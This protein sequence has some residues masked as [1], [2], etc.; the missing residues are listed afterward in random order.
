[1]LS[2]AKRYS[3]KFK[4]PSRSLIGQLRPKWPLILTI[5]LNELQRRCPF[6]SRALPRSCAIA[7]T[8]PH[9]KFI[10]LVL[11][12]TFQNSAAFAYDD[13]IN[14]Q[15]NLNL[16]GDASSLTDLIGTRGS[17]LCAPV[18]ITHGF[19]YLRDTVG[20]KSLPGD[21]AKDRI[22]QLYAKCGTDKERGTRYHQTQ[23]C[24][25]E[26]LKEAGYKPWVYIVGPH[27][28]NAPDGI[29]LS[30]MRHPLTMI[31]VKN[32]VKQRLMVIMAVGWYDL[33]PGTKTYKRIGGHFFN[34]YGYNWNQE[35][36]DS[37][38]ELIAVNSLQPYANGAPYD[39][40]Q[41]TEL[42]DDGT[43]YPSETKF[44]ITGPGFSFTQKTLVEDLFVVWPLAP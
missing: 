35:W 13:A 42:P 30:S 28:I 44:S 17:Q 11:A 2:C 24:L 18:S 27:A 29:A 40:V 1:M 15:P 37:K 43:L 41:M 34:V 3:A 38:I 32:Y 39:T 5:D 10:V 19:Q 7:K 23:S 9:M 16:Y 36:A 33:D 8:N 25:R 14:F 26:S 4:K 6:V 21:P 31:D 20:F 22:R 12:L